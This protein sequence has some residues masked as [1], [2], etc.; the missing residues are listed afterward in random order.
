M[1]SW[2]GVRR[3]G[4]QAACKVRRLPPRQ[5]SAL[6]GI[7]HTC[8]DRLVPTQRG[9]IL[10]RQVSACLYRLLRAH[11]FLV[12]GISIDKTAEAVAAETLVMHAPYERLA[13]FLQGPRQVTCLVNGRFLHCKPQ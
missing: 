5:S 4:P 8:T 6:L 2:E 9:S 11:M 12:Y 3:P 1:G 10:F 7:L 13:I